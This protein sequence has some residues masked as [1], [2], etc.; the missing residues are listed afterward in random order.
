MAAGEDAPHWRWQ[1]DALLLEIRGKPGARHDAIGRV[2][3]GRLAVQIAAVAEDGKATARL[4]AFLAEQFG[5]PKAAV[6][7]E[8][9]LTSPYKRIRIVAPTRLPPGAA[10]GPRAP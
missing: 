6:Q 9:G 2:A 10:I 8:S 5:V 1:G 7:L 3:G 4:L